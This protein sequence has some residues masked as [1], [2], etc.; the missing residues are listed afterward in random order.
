[1]SKKPSSRTTERFAPSEP[2]RSIAD[3]RANYEFEPSDPKFTSVAARDS[4]DDTLLH[5]AVFRGDRRDVR[6]LLAL[7]SDV[8]ARGDMGNTPLHYAAMQGHLELVEMLLAAGGDHAALNEWNPNPLQTAELS[9]HAEVAK[10]LRSPRRIQRSI[11][12]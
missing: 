12:G 5:K 8:N 4:D 3:I 1:L 10:V 6:D 7:S 9:G 11:S 2:S